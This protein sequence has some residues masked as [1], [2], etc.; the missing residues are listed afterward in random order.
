MPVA[1]NPNP[2]NAN[3]NRWT[4]VKSLDLVVRFL[5]ARE[6]EYKNSPTLGSVETETI[7]DLVPD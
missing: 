3:M 6:E 2:T 5:I 7:P 1:I 4:D